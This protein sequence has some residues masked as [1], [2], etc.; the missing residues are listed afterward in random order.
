MTADVSAQPHY[1]YGIEPI[2][3]MRSRFTAEEMRGY[4]RGNVIKYLSRYTLKNGVEDLRK[5]RVYL[6]WLIELE[7]SNG[8]GY[9]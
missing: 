4:L 2:D 1:A 8:E 6:N 7:A 5:A 3:F 9:G